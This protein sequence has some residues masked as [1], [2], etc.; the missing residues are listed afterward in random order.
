MNKLAEKLRKN[1]YDMKYDYKNSVIEI[2]EKNIIVYINNNMYCVRMYIDGQNFEQ[3]IKSCYDVYDFLVDVLSGK[4]IFTRTDETIMRIDNWK[5]YKREIKFKKRCQLISRILNV[6][7]GAGL[8]IFWLIFLIMGLL[9]YIDYT[10]LNWLED[11]TPV[12]TAVAG[13]IIGISMIHH[14]LTKNP[15][16]FGGTIIYGLGV[17]LTS[18]GMSLLMWLISDYNVTPKTDFFGAIGV[19]IMFIAL[20]IFMLIAG[21]RSERQEELNIKPT[22]RIIFRIPDLPPETDVERIVDTVKKKSEKEG[23]L[24]NPDTE[25]NPSV[26]DSKFGGL[27]YWDLSRPYPVDST[28]N[29]M[30]LLAQFNLSEIPENEKLPKEGMLQFFISVNEETKVVYHKS[31]DKSFRKDDIALLEI[32][33]DEVFSGECGISFQKVMMPMSVYD[34]TAYDLLHE[35]A[36]ELDIPLDKTIRLYEIYDDSDYLDDFFG[37]CLLGMAYFINYDIRPKSNSRYN[38]LLFQ[39]DSIENEKIYLRWNDCG[40]CQFFINDKDLSDMNFDD[41]FFGY[42]CY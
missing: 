10:S 15:I 36:K 17:N 19:F 4:I 6:I 42:D 16:S 11:S 37:S 38:T 34:Y 40:L 25:K 30:Q 20:G 8:A 26:F 31:I 1:G 7:V 14:G 28:S 9:Y 35:T 23:F 24:I 41:V 22:P 5:P 33:C 21:L 12:P 29:K 27:P 18:L 2:P 32:P 13:V 39:M 3:N